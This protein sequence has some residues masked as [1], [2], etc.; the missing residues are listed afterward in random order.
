MS[1]PQ[2]TNNQ[3]PKT[4]HQFKQK[5]TCSYGSKCKF[6][7]VKH[8]GP[9]GK[10]ATANKKSRRSKAPKKPQPKNRTH[11]KAFFDSYYPA[12]RYRK[13]RS[14]MTQFKELKKEYRGYW[15][16][17]DAER[18]HEAFK[19]ALTKD[20]NDIYGTD[21]KDLASWQKLCT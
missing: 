4:C 2:E 19:D 9:P 15:S 20:F 8:E 6:S 21:E 7:H 10:E 1:S 16:K 13:S 17:D 5:G 14:A 18:A 11:V 3:Q 12:F